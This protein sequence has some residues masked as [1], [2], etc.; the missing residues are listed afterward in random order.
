MK[1]KVFLFSLLLFFSPMSHAGWSGSIGY[2]NPPGAT[3]G[4]NLMHL[5]SR[6]AF[7]VGLGYARIGNDNNND[8]TILAGDLNLKY[9]FGGRGFRPYA[10][11]GTGYGFGTGQDGDGVG[12]GIGD[13]FFGGL[14][15]FAMG[16]DVYGY[17][18][19]N[20]GHGD[21]FLQVGVGV[22]F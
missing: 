10:Q 5:W 18:S 9:L 21:G 20:I 12:I 14:G 2:H 1:T 4:V 16:R 17:A 13:S 6:W 19:V 8:S 3:L 11:F 15:F 7:E 22:P